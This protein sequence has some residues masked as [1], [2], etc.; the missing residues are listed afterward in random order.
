MDGRRRVTLSFDNGP[1]RGVTDSV[2]D[3]LGERSLPAT[4][5]IIGTSLDERDGLRLVERA[6]AEGHWIGNHG[7]THEIQLVD[8][9][10][11]GVA[12]EIDGAQARLDGL[13][14]PDKF[15]R[16]FGGGGV[17]DTRLL[18]RRAVTH[19]RRGRYTCVLWN[20]VPRDWEAP[21]GWV[22]AALADIRTRPWSLVVLHDLPTGAMERLPSFLDRLADADVDVVH[23][24]PPACV[25]LRRGEPTGE[26]AWLLDAQGVSGS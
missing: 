21:E 9:D 25:P 1:V 13:A 8:L 14:H 17:I 10:D 23:D 12:R 16:P 18:G 3:A 7:L 24:F 26:L 11:E 4:F 5:F 20:C 15:F 6:H 22:E 2:L 19:L